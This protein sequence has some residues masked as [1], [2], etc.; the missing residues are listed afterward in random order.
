[1]QC[2]SDALKWFAM[3]IAARVAGDGFNG[4]N[5]VQKN[6]REHYPSLPRG[7]VSRTIFRIKNGANRVCLHGAAKLGQTFF[8]SSFPIITYPAKQK[9]N[10]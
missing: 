7:T 10:N 4:L 6:R 9:K 3:S 8:S 1:M 2:C 5:R